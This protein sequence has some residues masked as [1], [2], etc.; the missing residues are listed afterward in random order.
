MTE[1]KTR[2]GDK[3]G[4]PVLMW[5]LSR[6][7]K[8][9]LE[10]VIK[11]SLFVQLLEKSRKQSTCKHHALSFCRRVMGGRTTPCLLTVA[12]SSVLILIISRQL[13][14]VCRVAPRGS[15]AVCMVTAILEVSVGKVCASLVRLSWRDVLRFPADKERRGGRVKRFGS[16]KSAWLPVSR[17]E[18]FPVDSGTSFHACRLHMA[19]DILFLSDVSSLFS[20]G[21][22][23][24]GVILNSSCSE[25][26]CWFL[27]WPGRWKKPLSYAS[28]TCD[29]CISA[30][31]L[32]NSSWREMS[33]P[34][35]WYPVKR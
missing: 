16:L 19:R 23:R 17:Y 6:T 7:Y 22:L 28:F 18:G 8:R 26:F 34:V 15:S 1:P 32:I 9:L 14:C 12:L 21:D 31:L 10:N 30:C 27:C 11:P 33:E 4:W 5:Y 20:T 29:Q 35:T 13:P 3:A 2:W 25:V 24:H